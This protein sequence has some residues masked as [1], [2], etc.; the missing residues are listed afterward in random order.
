MRG[1]GE[2]GYRLGA[3]LLVVEFRK[4][5]REEAGEL[6]E[7]LVEE[8]GVQ[9]VEL[10]GEVERALVE[11]PGPD[12]TILAGPPLLL[13]RQSGIGDDD[14]PL[15]Q[16]ERR[17]PAQAGLPGQPPGADRVT[18]LR[19]QVVTAAGD[20]EGAG[21]VEGELLDGLV[22]TRVAELEVDGV[23]QVTRRRGCAAAEQP[24][25][26]EPEELGD[27]R[28]ALAAQLDELLHQ[29]RDEVMLVDAVAGRQIAEGADELRLSPASE[30]DGCAGILECL[31]RRDPCNL[32]HVLT[33]GTP[34]DIFP[35]PCSIVD[36]RGPTS[37]PRPVGYA[38]GATTRP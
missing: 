11:A 15:E 8:A 5:H 24:L 9:D 3:A 14:E 32:F 1:A 25:H 33:L 30:H 18:G 38:N 22:E 29:G 21:C 4:T 27:G 23:T 12:P 34:T 28:R 35:N 36:S 37:H 2:D 6:V 13:G 7:P 26:L 17:R 20:A 31:A 19:A 10:A 16:V